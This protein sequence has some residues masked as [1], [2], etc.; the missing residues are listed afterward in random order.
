MRKLVVVLA[1]TSLVFALLLGSV[2]TIRYADFSKEASK[3]QSSIP[4]MKE[5]V[6]SLKTQMDAMSSSG[7]EEQKQAAKDALAKAEKGIADL[8][9]MSPSKFDNCM[10]LAV[11]GLLLALVTIVSV[12]MK[13]PTFTLVVG[14][15]LIA[16]TGLIWILVPHVE[17]GQYGGMS[18]QAGALLQFI[19]SALGGALAILA[20]R[21]TPAATN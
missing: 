16:V 6:A 17:T 13:K 11:L 19:P 9:S 1:V 3:Y 10:M 8:E 18:P 5:S 20:K 15:A 2:C 7:S 21:M 14:G 12:F 4:M